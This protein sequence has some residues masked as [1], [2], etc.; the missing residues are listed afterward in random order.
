VTLLNN[1]ATPMLVFTARCYA[2]RG[3]AMANC[4]SVCPSATLRYRDHIGWKSSKIISR[5]VS[6]G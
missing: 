4:P 5:L 3:I 6:Q 2:K 1:G